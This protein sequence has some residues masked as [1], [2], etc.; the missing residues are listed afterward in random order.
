MKINRF[1]GSR[2]MKMVESVNEEVEAPQEEK[3]TLS[4]VL[5]DLIQKEWANIEV[6]NGSLIMAQQLNNTE[7]NDVLNMMLDDSYTHIGQFE[8]LLQNEIPEAEA[9]DDAKDSTEE[10]EVAEVEVEEPEEFEG[11]ID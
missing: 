3:L 10:V 5:S 1:E 11:E 8:G 4:A 6:I 2:P 9:I 7:L